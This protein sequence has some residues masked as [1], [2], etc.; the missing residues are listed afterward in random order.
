M[1]IKSYLGIFFS[2]LIV[3]GCIS[4]PDNLPTVPRIEFKSLEFVPVSGASDSLIVT[5]D[6]EDGEGDLGL[7]PTDNDPPFNALEFQRDSNGELITYSNRPSNAPP[8]NPID[9][10]VDPI[11]NNQTVK[12][13]VWVVQNPN[14]FNIFVK[15]FIKRNGEFTEFRWQDPPFYTTFNGRFPRILTTEEGQA[16]EGSIRYGM[17][18]SGWQSIF[19]TDTLMVEVAIQDR[20]LNRSNEVTSSEVTLNQIT[21]ASN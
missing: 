8:Y 15:F 16:V 9:W 19:R 20:A 1:R 21:R 13:T 10:V 6:F 3:Y 11:V 2:I 5:V 12:D 17:L 7:S 14:Q 4:P 18:S